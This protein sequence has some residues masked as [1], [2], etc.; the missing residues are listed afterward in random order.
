M[1]PN[2]RR[3]VR[4][5]RDQGIVA[6]ARR[7]RDRWDK[8]DAVQFGLRRAI[9]PLLVRHDSGPRT[10]DAPATTPIVLCIVRNGR[11]WL[12]SFLAH[13]RGLG[14]RHFVILDNGSTDGTPAALRQEGDVTL[15]TSTAPY[16]AYENT[17]KRYLVDR[18]GK[19]R[20]CLFVDIDEQFDFPSSRTRGLDGL[21]GYLDG[22]G[23]TAVVTQML[24]MFADRP[25]ADCRIDDLE[26]VRAMFP[27]CDL[28]SIRRTRYPFADIA[29]IE[30]HWDGVRKR[31]FGSDNGL[32]KISFF[33]NVSGLKTFVQW[34]H[35][36][37]GRIAD[38]SAVLFH[39]PFVDTFA[40]KVSDAVSSG[41]YGYRTSDE[42]AA[43]GRTT[44]APA[45]RITSPA[46]I[47]LGDVEELVAHRFLIASPAFDRFGQDRD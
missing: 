6:T 43:Y 35:V 46:A 26:S 39:Y 47:R 36:A 13:H 40:A 28:A 5:L 1:R 12:R 37:G 38:L 4:Q 25:L 41:R 7:A 3:R 31:V 45:F 19:D 29:P 20:W 27:L 2:L 16:R 9:V 11:P 22:H 30:M 23:Y 44:T 14:F 18:F 15:L 10:I 34:H 21:I 8:L 32:T 17:L 33:R 42:Y 24:D